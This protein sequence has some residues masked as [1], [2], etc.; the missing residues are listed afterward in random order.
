MFAKP[1]LASCDRRRLPRGLGRL[2]GHRSGVAY[3]TLHRLWVGFATAFAI[4]AAFLAFES[5]GAPTRI[6]RVAQAPT[7]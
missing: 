3:E 2:R 6:A 7:D 1:M 4:V 5:V